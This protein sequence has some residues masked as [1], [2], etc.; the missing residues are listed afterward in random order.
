L[1][2]VITGDPY[3]VSVI[4]ELTTP[5]KLVGVFWA[6]CNICWTWNLVTERHFEIL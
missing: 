1:K 3:M 6:Y 4:S 5:C 2:G